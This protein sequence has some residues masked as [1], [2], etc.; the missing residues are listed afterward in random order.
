MR[1]R[2]DSKAND[3]IDS[4]DRFLDTKEKLQNK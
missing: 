1:T 4:F 2:Y 3:I